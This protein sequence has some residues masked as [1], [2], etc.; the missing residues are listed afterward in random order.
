[1][2]VGMGSSNTAVIGTEFLKEEAK[3]RVVYAQD[4]T[5]GDP[6]AIVNLIFKVYLQ[7]GTD[8]TFIFVDGSNRAFVN[9]LKV[10][11]NES[12]NW[13]KSRITP[14]SMK[15]LPVNF[16]NEHKT[17]LSSLSMMISK[18][19]IAI[20]K[21][22]ETGKETVGDAADAHNEI[23][24]SVREGINDNPESES[25]GV[26]NSNSPILLEVPSLNESANSKPD[27]IVTQ[28]K[29]GDGR[30]S[31]LDMKIYNLKDQSFVVSNNSRICPDQNC[32]FQ[33][34]DTELVYQPGSND[35]IWKAL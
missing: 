14:D 6:Q 16:S 23:S 18:E 33:F 28:M 35:I 2:D 21:S 34:K 1:V 13:E 7:Y 8:N 24:K 19:Y 31:V 32:K 15:V 17:M 12:L 3:I 22:A 25:S 4:W 9:L 29:F 10:T 20:P 11:F 27:M 5:H 26:Q 30:D